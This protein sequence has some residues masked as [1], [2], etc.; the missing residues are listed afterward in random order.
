VDDSENTSPTA[1]WVSSGQTAAEV[2]STIRGLSM[3]G[4]SDSPG[5]LR[6]ADIKYD[7]FSPFPFTVTYVQNIGAYNKG[8]YKQGWWWYHGIDEVTLNEKLAENN[9]RPVSLKA[10]QTGHDRKIRF[11][12]VMISNTGDD[13]KAYWYYYGRTW[14]E[15][16]GLTKTNNA[17]LTSLQSYPSDGDTRYA[18]IMIANTGNDLKKSWWYTNVSPQS[19]RN[20]LTSNNARP[21]QVTYAGSGNFNAIMESC[22]GGC[23]QWSWH[24]GL[25]G[26]Q[27]L[28]K[29]NH[30]N[31][32]II[33]TD[34]YPGCGSYCF[35][36]VM[37]SGS[38]GS[39]HGY[40]P[41]RLRG[42][43][44]LH[45]HPLSNLGFGG[46]LLYGGVDVGSL[47]P[48]DPDCKHNVRAGSMEQALGHDNSTH[49]GP[50]VNADPTSPNF[51]VQNPCG[52][53]IR[54]KVIHGVQEGNKAEDEADDASGAPN[55]RD[56]PVWKDITH[57][58]MWVDWIRRAYDGGLRVMVALAVNNKTLADMTAGPGDYPTDDKSSADLQIAETKAFVS[59]HNDFMEIAYSSA[60]LQ[61]IVQA[62]K[63]AVVLGVEID[64]IGNFSRDAGLQ[65]NAI[66][67]EID[68]L[69]NEGVRYIF[70]V[71]IIDNAFGGTAVYNSLF[72]YSN[73]RESGRFWNL[74]CA[75]DGDHIT[76]RFEPSNDILSIAGVAAKLGLEDALRFPPDYQNCGQ[77]NAQGLTLQGVFA[78]HE[79]MKRGMLIDIDHMSQTSFDMALKIAE[80]WP[81]GYPLFS[82][83]SSLRTTNDPEKSTERNPTATQYARIA[84]LHGMVG[85]GSAEMDSSAWAK[86]Y[87]RILHAMGN[88]NGAGFGT[89]TNGLA[90]GMPAPTQTTIDYSD[91]FQMS[92]VGNTKWNYNEVGVA[93]YGMIFDFVKDVR[94]TLGGDDLV[95]NNLMYG[96]EYFYQTW[97]LAD[98]SVSGGNTFGSGPNPV[99]TTSTEAKT[100]ATSDVWNGVWVE[101]T[102]TNDSK[103]YV[104]IAPTADKFGSTSIPA[105][106]VIANEYQRA[107]SANTVFQVQWPQEGSGELGLVATPLTVPQTVTNLR[108]P[109][110]DAIKVGNGVTLYLYTIYSVSAGQKSFRNYAIRYVRQSPNGSVLVDV[111]L[112]SV[113]SQIK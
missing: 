68:R 96:A 102:T 34:T 92:Q 32:R 75:D 4:F 42:F 60:D 113:R 15:I 69:Y 3:P 78:I 37:M 111:F 99:I 64:K 23:P 17:R 90:K 66:T 1:W 56:W 61:R 48:A 49:G 103:Y 73:R 70:P 47:L 22:S 71:H 82:G 57:Q 109:R 27:I 54:A 30:E 106:K 41:Q 94:N 20:S 45:T 16:N 46:K 24:W 77:R 53:A 44:D 80:T 5:E 31:A 104:Y 51:G 98:G 58:K 91:S 65:N 88:N 55:F 14:S 95:D 11:T 10:Y 105:H 9:A 84:K 38:T 36:A 8:S 7:N 13:R 40:V 87:I 43:V 21:V 72:N 110:A 86:M 33:S 112:Q 85:V 67:A 107:G 101:G 62:N 6:I 63:L 50:G 29:A 74:V 100:G 83:H 89:D 39:Q 108:P 79:M 18:V 52:D 28:A 97:K 19:V 25:S 12:V 2:D 76:Y 26:D 35:V 81:G 93:H 59:R